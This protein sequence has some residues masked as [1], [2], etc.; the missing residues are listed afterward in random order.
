[1]DL[2]ITH[3]SFR[4]FRSYEEFDLADIGPLTVFVGPNAAGKTNIV[5]GIQLL[6][7]QT[8]FRHPTVEQLVRSGAPW[9]HLE[10]DVGDGSRQLSLEVHL[11]EGKKRYLVNDKVK[12]TADV[13]GLIP[14]VTFTPD[15]LELAKGAMAVR[16]TALDALG[17]QLSANH[18]LIRRDYE[19]VLRHK[20]RLLKDDAD[21]SLVE[22]INETLVTCGAQLSCYRS[23]L[24]EKLANSM[25]SY[26]AEITGGCETLRACYVPSWV[27]HDPNVLETYVFGRDEARSALTIALGERT[28]DERERRRALVGP[29]AD[30]IE[31]FIDGK[32]VTVYGSQGQQ[33]S[34]V[35]AFKLA[36]A[37]L[38]QDI[39]HQKPILLLDDV[40][41]ELDAARRRALVAFIAGDIQ[42]FITTTNLAYFDNDL[43][44]SARVVELSTREGGIA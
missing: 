44:A 3:I 30:K 4:N 24:F 28:L 20:N 17:S 12:R 16:R 15:D 14:S 37:S 36:E 29:H 43:L 32:N 5:E 25:A 21:P 31:F 22:A 13:K 23:A 39:L 8:S 9:G 19:K 41:S 6:T 1:M 34:V 38:I 27:S 42:T 33:R 26:Y 2:S 7:A 35:L 18:Y 11:V 10:A 40:M